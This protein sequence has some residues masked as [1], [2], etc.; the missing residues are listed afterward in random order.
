ML[1]LINAV[2]HFS[3]MNPTLY[4]GSLLVLLFIVLRG[5][6][7]LGSLNAL[8]MVSPVPTWAPV[9]PR[10]VFH[11]QS[12]AILLSVANLIILGQ[13]EA[14]NDLLVFTLAVKVT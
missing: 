11:R 8:A 10:C 3:V 6:Y 14:Q 2:H 1:Q 7:R 5:W 13:A 12:H 4:F 9:R